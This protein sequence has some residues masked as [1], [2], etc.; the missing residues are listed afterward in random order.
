VKLQ[1][2][3]RNHDHAAAHF[4]CDQR[5]ANGGKCKRGLP[6]SGRCHCE[7]TRMNTSFQFPKRFNLP[8][9]EPDRRRQARNPSPSLDDIVQSSISIR[10]IAWGED[11]EVE[12]D[13]DCRSS[14]TPTLEL[15]R[16]FQLLNARA[17]MKRR[18][19][20]KESGKLR[21]QSG[22]GENSSS[23]QSIIA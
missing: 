6:G 3:G 1:V 17:I 21:S 22:S 10:V 18:F 2:L 7:K 19:H 8:R 11:D 5:P 4:T 14:P 15:L 12:M 16:N 13:G 20:S 9:S 23:N